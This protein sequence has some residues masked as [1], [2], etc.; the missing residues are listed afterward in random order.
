MRFNK[1]VIKS[2]FEG[3][4]AATCNCEQLKSLLRSGRSN[5]APVS[6]V[7]TRGA[8]DGLARIFSAGSG[9]QLSSD[10]Q[11]VFCKQGRS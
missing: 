6:P 8:L 5:L 7:E 3:D 2:G 1:V 11:I 10:C 4:R 9:K